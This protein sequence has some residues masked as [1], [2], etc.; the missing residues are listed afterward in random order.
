MAQN[1]FNDSLKY[2]MEHVASFDPDD[3]AI[4]RLLKYHKILTVTDMLALDN[5]QYNGMKYKQGNQTKTPALFEMNRLFHLTNYIREVLKEEGTFDLEAEMLMRARATKTE[6]NEHRIT[7]RIDSDGH[8]IP[9]SYLPATALTATGSVHPTSKAYELDKKIKLDA[10]KYPVLKR[11][12]QWAS[13]YDVFAATAKLQGAADVL[14]S[15]YKPRDT[16]AKELFDRLQLFMYTVFARSLLTPFGKSLVSQHNSDHDSQQIWVKLVQHMNRSIVGETRAQTMLEEIFS[17]RLDLNTWGDTVEQY[18]LEWRQRVEQLQDLSVNDEYN[19]QPKVLLVS[20]QN[21]VAGVPE[22]HDIKTTASV[23]AASNNTTVTYENYY[24]LLLAAGQKLDRS[25]KPPKASRRRRQVYNTSIYDPHGDSDNSDTDDNDHLSI[26]RSQ[27]SQ[28]SRSSRSSGPSGKSNSTRPRMPWHIWSKLSKE[29]QTAWDLISD[30]DKRSILRDN[31]VKAHETHYTDVS[32]STYYDIQAHALNASRPTSDN[33]TISTLSHDVATAKSA[34]SAG[35]HGTQHPGDL[36]RMMSSTNSSTSKSKSTTFANTHSIIYDVHSRTVRHRQGSLVDRCANG[37]V[38][39]ADVRAVPSAIEA[40]RT[41]DIRGVDNMTVNDIPIRTVAGVIDTQHGPVIGVFHNYAWLGRGKTIHSSLQLASYYNDVNDRHRNEPNGL[42]RIVTCEGYIIPLSYRDGMPEMDIRPYTDHEWDNLPH[43]ILTDASEWDPKRLDYEHNN[44]TFFDSID[45][46]TV[47]PKTKLPVRFHH[48][49]DDYG[50]YRHRHIATHKWLRSHNESIVFR[51]SDLLNV[52]RIAC[53]HD[54]ARRTPDYP[55]YRRFLLWLPDDVIE[56]TWTCTTQYA[57]IPMSTHL[58]KT[59]QAPNPVLNIPRRPEDLATDEVYSDTP[60]IDNGATRAQ[61]FVGCKTLVSDVLPMKTEKQFKDKLLDIIRFRGAPTRLI[62]DSAQVEISKEIEDILR[63]YMT[64]A[65]QSEPYHQHQNPAERRFQTLKQDV[66]RVLDRTGAPDDCWLL[67]LQYVCFIRNRVA[68]ESLDWRAPLEVLLGVTPDISVLLRF[69]FYERVYCRLD[70]PTFPSDS[71]EVI[72]YMV[73]F[74]EHTGHAL[75]YKILTQDTRKVIYRSEVRS[76]AD[77]NTLNLREMPLDGEDVASRTPQVLKSRDIEQHPTK[78]SDT[79]FSYKKILDPHDLVGRTFLKKP[80]DDNAPEEALRVRIRQAIQRHELDLEENPKRQEYL[81]TMGRE[82]REELMT[83]AEILQH[84][85]SQDDDE[86]VWTFQQILAHQGPL[87]SNHPDYKGSSY[88]VKLQ[89]DTGEVTYEPLDIIAKDDPLSC[90]MYA[91]EHGL[92]DTDGWKRFK[93]MAKNHKKLVRQIN[94]AKLRSYR[95]APRFM[96]GYEIPRDYRH[97]KQIDKMNGNTKW[98]DCTQLEMQQMF[99]YKTFKN[100]G[101]GVPLPEDYTKIRVHLVYAVKHDGRHKARLVAD[102]HLTDIPIESVYSG[103]VSL[104][105]IRMSV[106]LAEL[107]GLETWCT[108]VGNAYLE[109][110]TKEKVGIIAGPEFGEQIQGCTLIIVKALYGLR[111]SGL[112]WHERL[113]DCLREQGFTPCKA[114]PDIWMRNAGD[115]YEYVAV[116]VDDLLFV[117]KDPQKFTDALSNPKGRYKFKLKGTGQISFHLGCDFLRDNHG[118][119][120]MSPKKYIQKM[121]DG[122]VRIFGEKPKQIYWSPLEEGDHPELDNSE[123]LTQDE[124]IKYQSLVGSMQWAV[125]LGRI[126][127]ATSVMTLSSFRSAPRRGHL[128]RAKRVIGYLTRFKDS[129]IRFRVDL[130][131]MT[132]LPE[133]QHEWDYSVYADAKEFTPDDA[134][135]PKGPTVITTSYF[136]A[137]LYHDWVTGRSVSGILHFLNQ[138]PIDWYTKKQ[139]TVE[140]ATF[141]SEFVSGRITV[142]QIVD[143]RTTLRYLGVNI[144]NKAYMFGDNESMVVSC[145]FPHSKLHKR[146]NA[147]SFHRV[148]EAVASGMLSLHHM[149][150]KL[151]P[152]D[153]LSKHWAYSKVWP[154]LQPLLFW[155]G[156]TL[157]CHEDTKHQDDSTRDTSLDTTTDDYTCEEGEPT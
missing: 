68:H 78:D 35:Q 107:N 99:D 105:G 157:L 120:T 75:T 48:A 82:E 19:L 67:A 93:R 72:G 126:D 62:S 13:W 29:S 77:P 44:D 37:G 54:V 152:A 30:D 45:E 145:K 15:T 153:I 85:E 21:A 8:P 22:L 130:P 119:L 149:P 125:S 56:R 52:E 84:L 135:E 150:G 98:A 3:D 80:E 87:T 83:Y 117:M 115:H 12:S 114:E 55:R 101:R 110:Y 88:N 118:I 139:A 36:T 154:M 2:L 25:R 74:A 66:N 73:G 5:S 33:T 141:G 129:A 156:D 31:D 142:D 71:P 155:S 17:D 40:Q 76:A 89:W 43:V 61:L 28:P 70:D 79:K 9:D 1:E 50:D 27:R 137:N 128:N 60:A 106:F 122:Y 81:V 26:Y 38:A 113:A 151:N 146:H 34:A 108:D 131:D 20:L 7:Q 49:F 69:S 112:R 124:I 123:L 58:R 111:S 4:P 92:L 133:Q 103:V 96:Y 10:D 23:L 102:G 143:L 148:R 65:W 100:I 104:R 109:S 64:G 95:T 57:T 147:L 136:D 134:P 132:D 90:A 18:L 53:P 91:K 140:T 6:F 46:S 47:P 97:A 138:T 32:D 24:A 86:K 39:G 59:F 42:S 16:S 14:D 51:N 144:H 41:V 63:T 11:E 94:Q 121:Y 116:Y 127:I